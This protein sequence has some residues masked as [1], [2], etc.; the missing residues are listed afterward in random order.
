LLII[1]V[2]DFRKLVFDNRT[3]HAVLLL[4]NQKTTSGLQQP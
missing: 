1:T 4:S 3:D 2:N